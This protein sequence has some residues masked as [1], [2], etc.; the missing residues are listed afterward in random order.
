MP[1]LVGEASGLALV[2]FS[3]GALTA[4]S[5]ATRNR[6]TIDIDR[7]FAAFGA[8]NVA[9]ALSQ[10]FAVTGADSRTAMADAAGGRTQ[11]TGIAAAVTISLVLMFFTEPLQYVPTRR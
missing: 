2:L 11:M 1:S 8:A 4:R 3:S 6:Y 10:G 9:S 7:E 5:F